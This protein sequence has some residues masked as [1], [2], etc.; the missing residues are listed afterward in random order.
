M[1]YWTGSPGPAT[2][3]LT[4]RVGSLQA[5]AGAAKPTTNAALELVN[6]AASRLNLTSSLPLCASPVPRTTH[7]PPG[8][9]AE[10]IPRRPVCQGA[11]ALSAPCGLHR[12]PLPRRHIAE[13]LARLSH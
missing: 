10:P 5:C 12:H 11:L 13:A 6:P 3:G 2:V 8:R 7:G 4:P 1:V 9:C